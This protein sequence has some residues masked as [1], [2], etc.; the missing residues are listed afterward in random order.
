[1]YDDEQIGSASDDCTVPQHETTPSRTGT[2][3]QRGGKH[4]AKQQATRNTQTESENIADQIAA[5]IGRSLG[6]LLNRKD[7]LTQQLSEVDEQIAAVRTRISQ[8]LGE[9][10]PGADA[11]P[12]VRPATSDRRP[13][14]RGRKRKRVISAETR[15]KMSAAARR[16]WERRRKKK[17]S[18]SEAAAGR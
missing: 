11:R 9:Y 2:N 8:Q 4:V 13:V 6:E 14:R 10:I 1:M 12:R 3:A 16:R 17:D 18:G 15:A 7:A 5:Y